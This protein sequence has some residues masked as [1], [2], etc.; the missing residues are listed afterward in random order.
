M[1]PPTDDASPPDLIDKTTH[2]IRQDEDKTTYKTLDTIGD[3]LP[4]HTP[5]FI[6][7]SYPLTLVRRDT[8]PS[9]AGP[10]SGALNR[11][12]ARTRRARATRSCASTRATV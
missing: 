8:P 10:S 6:L 5:R 3:D 1:R 12:A 7:L 11:R 2:E 9:S 4:D